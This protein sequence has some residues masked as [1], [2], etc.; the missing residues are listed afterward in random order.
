MY[1]GY[2]CCDALSGP[3]RSVQHIIAL[4]RLDACYALAE[5]KFCDTGNDF[6]T[7]VDVTADVRKIEIELERGKFAGI[8]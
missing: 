6:C 4:E 7:A 3:T 5:A 8:I 1:V 2:T